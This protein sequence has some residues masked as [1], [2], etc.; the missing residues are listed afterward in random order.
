MANTRKT[1]Y[2]SL[3]GGVNITTP[4]LEIPEGDFIYALNMEP[5]KTNGIRSAQ[6]YERI[7]GNHTDP[8]NTGLY[9]FHLFS[10]NL[11]HYVFH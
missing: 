11:E 2:V 7:D 3:N 6:G 5:N 10:H 8:S 4:T 1:S 9:G